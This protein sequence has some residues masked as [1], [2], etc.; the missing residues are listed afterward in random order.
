MDGIHA[1]RDD[2]PVVDISPPKET[3]V[4]NNGGRAS[5]FEGSSSTLSPST[6]G[7]F[8]SEIQAINWSIKETNTM[9][10]E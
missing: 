3:S 2:M 1:Y 9:T 5:D 10:D 8:G 7:S 4:E 6:S